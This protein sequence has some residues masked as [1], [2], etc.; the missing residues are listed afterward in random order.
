MIW[1][2]RCDWHLIVIFQDAHTEA[3]EEWLEPLLDELDRHPRSVIQPSVDG[4]EPNTLFYKDSLT[5]HKGAFSW[6]L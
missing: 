2:M 4:I 3:N 6:D 1:L 5:K